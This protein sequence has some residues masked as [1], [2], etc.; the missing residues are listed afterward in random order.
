MDSR[1]LFVDVGMN[2]GFYTLL[3][4]RLGYRTEGFEIQSSL[5]PY[6]KASLEENLMLPQTSGLKLNTS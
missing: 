5:H 1:P 2:L 6:I 3:A 4:R